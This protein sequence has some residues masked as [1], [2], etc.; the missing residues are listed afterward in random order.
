MEEGHFKER[1]LFLVW[2]SV[3]GLDTLALKTPSAAFDALS[4]SWDAAAG[5]IITSAWPAWILSCRPPPANDRQPAVP[6]GRQYP[7]NASSGQSRLAGCAFE[8]GRAA[9]SATVGGLAVNWKIFAKNE[10]KSLKVKEFFE[11]PF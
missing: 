2:R 10:V 5:A 1:R 9:G 8:Q 3:V 11:K 7:G 6:Q 4:C